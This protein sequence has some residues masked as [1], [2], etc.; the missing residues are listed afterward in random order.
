MATRGNYSFRTGPLWLVFFSIV[1]AANFSNTVFISERTSGSLEVFI[2]SGLS[3]NAILYGKMLFTVLMIILTGMACIGLALLWQLLNLFHSPA[4]QLQ[5]SDFIL[6][7]SSSFVNAASAAYLSVRLS[8]PRI[9][10]VANLFV[11]GGITVLYM[12]FS[13]FY[14]L[15]SSAL[16]LLLFLLGILLT[17]LARKEFNSER[18]IQPMEL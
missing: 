7:F 14:D 5:T 9:L 13:T 10:P 2:T 1:V 12:L 17:F 16:T 11:F 6:Y 15:P 18:I 8:S 4:L 3:R